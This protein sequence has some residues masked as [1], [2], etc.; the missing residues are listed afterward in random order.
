MDFT[1]LWRYNQTMDFMNVTNLSRYVNDIT[2]D[3]SYGLA[4]EVQISLL[5]LY[6]I[7]VLL[8]IGGNA[9]VVYVVFSLQRLRN[10]T[11]VYIVN[12][13]FSDI[14]VTSLCIPFTVISNLVYYYWPFGS[15]LC[16]F[17]MYIQLTVVLQ[18]A[19]TL[20]AMTLDRHYAI[21]K[22]LQRRCSKREAKYVIGCIWAIAA[23]VALPTAVS[24]NIIY[25]PY[26]PGNQG[27]CTEVW[28]SQVSRYTYSV[29]I[30]LLQYFLPLIIMCV[31][32]VHIAIIIWVKRTPGEADN[33]RDIRL[34][35]SKKKVKTCI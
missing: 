24:T 8:S 19:M 31:T 14:I 28:E 1:L 30:M 18:R 20:V 33:N 5:C 23:F 11:N 7:T 22:P 32:Y 26:E 34:A 15:F 16:P 3:E 25:L 12:L 2:R 27:L 10:V 17:V 35:A 13:S 6:A 9:L 4:P 29:N 21:W